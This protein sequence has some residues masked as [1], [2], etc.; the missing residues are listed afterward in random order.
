MAHAQ[1]IRFAA[2]GN[3][4]HDVLHLPGKSPP[5]AFPLVKGYGPDCDERGSARSASRFL[6]AVVLLSQRRW[7]TGSTATS[8]MFASPDIVPF[9]FTPNMQHLLGPILTEGVLASGIMAIARSLTEPEVSTWRYL[10]SSCRQLIQ[11]Q[12]ELEQQLCLFARDE[13][14]TWL[15]QHHRGRVPP[16]DHNFRLNVTNNIDAIIKRAETMACK[17]EREQV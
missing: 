6:I 12:C 4:F 9:R 17:T 7:F 8:P 11:S 16:I 1:R 5:F 10:Y 3:E 15:H 14:M 2:R 13:V